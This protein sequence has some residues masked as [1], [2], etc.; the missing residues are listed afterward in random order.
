[1]HHHKDKKNELIKQMDQKNNRLG[2]QHSTIPQKLQC[3]EEHESIHSHFL[4][5]S[6]SQ[7][8]LP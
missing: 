4:I 5:G 1:M 7:F 2:T 3:K 8:Q 6:G